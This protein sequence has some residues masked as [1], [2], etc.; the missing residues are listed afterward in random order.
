MVI[1]N[2]H[3]ACIPVHVEGDV[4][5]DRVGEQ[6]GQDR[7]QPRDPQRAPHQQPVERLG[8]RGDIVGEGELADQLQI[9]LRPEAEQQHQRQR[10][11]QQRQRVE[12][13]R[14]DHD[15]PLARL[16]RP[17]APQPIPSALPG[18]RAGP[19]LGA[20]VWPHGAGARCPLA[21]RH[22]SGFGLAHAGRPGGSALCAAP[23]LM[24]PRAC[25]GSDRPSCRAPA[26]RR[27]SARAARRAD[28]RDSF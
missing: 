15:E 10:H 2:S 5:G 19:C 27:R 24:L 20:C 17:P 4:I 28:G 8:P 6:H 9:V 25:A 12:E 22:R 13:G 16:A 23:P 18:P 14:R 1:R 26:A 21:R 7:R 3:S 11:C